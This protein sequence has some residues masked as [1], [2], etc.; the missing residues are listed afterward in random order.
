MYMNEFG[1][2]RS[3]LWIDDDYSQRLKYDPELGECEDDCD[4]IIEDMF[5]EGFSTKVT[6]IRDIVEALLYIDNNFYIFDIVILDVNLN[7]GIKN[8]KPENAFKFIEEKFK[9]QGIAIIDG[10]KWIENAG[11][12]LFLYLT[13]KGF[14]R[15]NIKMLTA[16]GT[17]DSRGNEES[18]VSKWNEK[19]R[20]AGLIS[21]KWYDKSRQS[22]NSMCNWL[23]CVTNKREDNYYN[24]Y[25][26]LFVKMASL[27]KQAIENENQNNSTWEM[28]KVNEVNDFISVLDDIIHL[29][30][31]ITDVMGM[32]LIMNILR[33]LTLKSDKYDWSH[34]KYENNQYTKGYMAS[35]KLFRNWCA[36]DIVRLT[37]KRE[38][39]EFLSILFILFMRLNFSRGK[40]RELT[41]NQNYIDEYENYE[42]CILAYKM[43]ENK[44]LV[45][46]LEIDS[47]KIL[48][49][50]LDYRKTESRIQFNFDIKE[51]IRFLGDGKFV[52]NIKVGLD[53]IIKMY[54]FTICESE[55]E[56]TDGK[57]RRW[58]LKYKLLP[59]CSNCNYKSE[60]IIFKKTISCVYGNEK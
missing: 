31:N 11:Y 35:G 50:V 17:K 22:V 58:N 60:E 6:L 12:Y 55:A 23:R 40:L 2:Y 33:E 28:D 13:N 52:K 51:F 45:E 15:N 42:K 19:F 43:A 25:R 3:I 14:P 1:R 44:F 54:F 5:G 16:Y 59:Y 7:T 26:H 18:L 49:R 39:Y 34:I 53:D 32:N 24:H 36:H 21:P 41:Y 48:R 29:P 4:K 8:D 37:K 20:L 9:E 56:I 57:D 47:Y 10:E 30:Y 27:L 46:Q 38:D